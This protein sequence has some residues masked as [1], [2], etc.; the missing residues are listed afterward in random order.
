M[1]TAVALVALSGSVLVATHLL[2]ACAGGLLAY[3][4]MVHCGKRCHRPTRSE[5]PV[6]NR[7]PI[8]RSTWL[9]FVM[10]VASSMVVAIGVAA[11]LQTD[12]AEE[13]DAARAREVAAYSECISAWGG[14]LVETINS[15]GAVRRVYDEAQTDRADATADVVRIVLL[16]RK[17]P[18]EA[19]ARELDQA[20]ARAAAA[21]DR[22]AEAKAE[23]DMAP[24]YRPPALTCGRQP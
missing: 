20:L 16:L 2:A 21:D 9:G 8:R 19:T 1:T 6:Q 4:A 7:R 17:V 13:A 15:R 22:V 11:Y 12:E 14:D 3:V 23:L 10:I 24:I 18:P 5:D